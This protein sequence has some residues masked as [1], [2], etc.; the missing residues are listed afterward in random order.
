MSTGIDD[1]I[2]L[3]YLNYTYPLEASLHGERRKNSITG[4]GK[5][6]KGKKKKVK[7]KKNKRTPLNPD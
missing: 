2:S 5:I 3:K 1:A 7:G 6:R 4:Q